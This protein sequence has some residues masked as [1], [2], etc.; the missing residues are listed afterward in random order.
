[1]TI[2]YNKQFASQY[3]FRFFGDA[4]PQQAIDLSL[5]GLFENSIMQSV[6]LVTKADMSNKHNRGVKLQASRDMAAKLIRS[7]RGVAK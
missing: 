4:A 1:M 7:A 6:L 3:E 2:T 5:T